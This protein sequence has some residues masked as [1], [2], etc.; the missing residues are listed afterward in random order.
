[1]SVNLTPPPTGLYRDA[2]RRA[3]LLVAVLVAASADRAQAADLT[4]VASSF[5]VGNKFDFRFRVRYDHFEERAQLKREYEGLPGQETVEV[6]KDL[7]YESYRDQ[8]ALRAEIGLWHDLMLYL[9]LPVIL[10][11]AATYSFDQ[12]AGAG[13]VYTGPNP[14]C[15]APGTEAVPGNSTTVNDRIVP[16]GG[17]DATNRGIVFPWS[18]TPGMGDTHVFRGVQRGA[19]GGSGG[20]AF[21]TLNLG[22]TWAPLSQARDDTK[23]TWTVK[24]EGQ[25]SIGNVMKFDRAQPDANHAVSDGTHRLYVQTA[26]SKRFRW[27]EPYWS[28]W[29][30]LPIGKSDSLFIDYG[31][32]QKVKNPQQRAGTSFGAEVVPFERPERHYKL[33]IDLRGRVEGHFDG[34]GYSEAWELLAG[35]PALACDDTQANYNPSCKSSGP[36]NPYN[37]HPSFTGVTTIENYAT[38]GVDLAVQAQVGPYVRFRTGFLYSHD[39]SHL[40]T[41]DDIGTPMNGSVRVTQPNEFNP[42]YR[43]L[44]DQVGRRYK[45]DNVNMY[46]FYLWAQMMF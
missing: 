14:N 35:S 6:R 32:T 42:A 30:L 18:A 20:D 4:D 24:I 38:L 22:V 5:D 25:F 21:D 45:V 7:L 43:P 3:C 31:P 44:I 1:M 29:Y 27:L 8:L 34:R 37:D 16:F 40:V 28:A 23:P 10:D 33:A 41:G 2:M 13:C 11:Q 19:R 46:D 17:Y 15:V 12:S 26:L 39:E 36:R 9:E